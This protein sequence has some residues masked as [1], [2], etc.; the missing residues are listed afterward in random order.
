MS[1][2]QAQVDGNYPL[3][4]MNGTDRESGE[5]FKGKLMADVTT[6]MQNITPLTTLAYAH[7]EKDMAKMEKILGLTHDEMHENMIKAAEERGDIAPLKIALTLEK[8]AE[9]LAPERSFYILSK[10]FRGYRTCEEY[11]FFES[12]ILS[13]TPV[14]MRSKM[15]SF[16]KEVLN[17]SI[18]DAYALSEFTRDAT[19][20]WGIDHESIMEEI[21]NP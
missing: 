18:S 14:T 20:R 13:I 8:S 2:S 17:T 21:I 6:T 5:A 11:F 3:I 1:V 19:L 12:I 7:K 9:A 16:L 10:L 4:V 15:D